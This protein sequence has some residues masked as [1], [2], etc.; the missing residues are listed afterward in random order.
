MTKILCQLTPSF[1]FCLFLKTWRLILFSGVT[2]FWFWFTCL[3]VH[4]FIIRKNQLYQIQGKLFSILQTNWRKWKMTCRIDKELFEIIATGGSFWW[5]LHLIAQSDWKK[6]EFGKILS[7][8]SWLCFN[9]FGWAEWM[10]DRICRRFAL[11]YWGKHQDATDC[12]TLIIT[13]R[14]MTQ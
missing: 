3:L 8:L 4:P 9:V 7:C 2:S 1:W 12:S 5:S 11:K 10:K 6:F 14:S 13:Q